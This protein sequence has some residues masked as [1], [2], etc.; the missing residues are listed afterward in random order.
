[1]LVHDHGDV[2]AG[3]EHAYELERRVEAGRNEGAHAA[4][5]DL[6]D[7]IAHGGDIGLA[8]Q[9][10]RLEPILGR[11]QRRQFPIREM[12]GEHQGRLAVAAQLP[13]PLVD[14]AAVD[15]VAHLLRVG[16]EHLQAIDMGELG[17]N[18]AEIV[19][20]AAQDRFDFGGGFFRKGGEVG[21]ADLVLL[22]SRTKR[23]HEAGG[24]VG[25]VLAVG[26][27]DGPQHPHRQ[28][29]ERA[30]AARLEMPADPMDESSRRDHGLAAARQ[31]VTTIFPNTCRLSIRAS[32][33]SKS[34]SA[35]SVSIT[36]NRP[37][38]ILARL[39]RMLRMEAPNEPMMRYCCWKSC[40]KLMV[41]DGPEVEPQVTSRP[42]RLRQRSEPLKVSAPTCSNTTS[43]PFL[44][45][46]LRTAPSKR[47]VR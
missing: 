19:P 21:A 47:S 11:N 8:V 46:I 38:A 35:T 43:T 30:V 5:A 26:C 9:H 16:I 32:P 36:G 24:E 13:K 10:R 34:A 33:R 20:N 12:G 40:I 27:A 14:F 1:M 28:P 41:V 22:E 17:S 6:D 42:P 44:A 4:F 7:R 2:A 15:D 23:A 3:F 39:S 37:S 18:A 45:V 31:K 25:H 29:T